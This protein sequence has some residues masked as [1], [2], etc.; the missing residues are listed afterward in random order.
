[1]PSL[2]AAIIRGNSFCFIPVR[3]REVGTA[4]LLKEFPVENPEVLLGYLTLLMAQVQ[5]REV[6]RA[7]G[8]PGIN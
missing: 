2:P 7:S 8:R 3:P 1:M 4:G 6:T 5:F